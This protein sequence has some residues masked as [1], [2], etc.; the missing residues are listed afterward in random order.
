MKTKFRWTY[1]DFY[2]EV[3][4]NIKNN[5]Y[6]KH[7]ETFMADSSMVEEVNGE[8]YFHDRIFDTHNTLGPQVVAHSVV[9]FKEPKFIY[10]DEFSKIQL[11]NP[12][13]CQ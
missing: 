2:N 11:I 3:P 12:A 9:F 8:F 5:K 1:N 10:V 6:L 13:L 4:Q 7:D